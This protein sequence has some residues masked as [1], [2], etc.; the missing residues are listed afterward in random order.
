MRGRGVRR[1]LAGLVAV[2]VVGAVVASTTAG[3][4]AAAEPPQAGRHVTVASYN[5]Y[6]GADLN[7]LFNPAVDTLPELVQAAGSVYAA[8]VATNFPERAKTLA[9]LIAEEHPDVLG[10]QEV[11]LWETAPAATGAFTTTYD[12]LTTLRA[13]LAAAGTPYDVVATNHNFSGTAPISPTT[14]A[15]FTDSDVILVPADAT[16]R[17]VKVSNVRE[18][19][20]FAAKLPLAIAGQAIS[21]VRGWSTVDLQVRGLKFRLANTHL[22]AFGGDVVRN[23]Q[24][25]ELAAD[26][27]ASPLPVVLTGD[28]NS[29][30]TG[31]G[32]TNT[33]A[34]AT[35]VDGLGLAESWPVAHPD[36]P[37]G[38]PTSGQAADL[39]NDPSEIDHRID[40]V[41]FD[42]D[43]FTA[44]HAEVLGEEEADRTSP[45]G[46]WPSD[47]AGSV[48]RLVAVP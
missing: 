36:D 44:T 32:N 26:L 29:R 20:I 48:A 25:T 41:V 14:L 4:A 5:L 38:G 43:A 39:L 35:L 1:V 11:A 18:E 33:V 2:T 37:C 16:Y 8:M 28:L 34:Y 17:Q 42:P 47:H 22:E 46:F 21:V 19:N 9:R 24:A 40:F 6:L 45:T 12:F 23:L 15:R 3:A 13:E 10:L 30:P 31:C 7:P 27:A